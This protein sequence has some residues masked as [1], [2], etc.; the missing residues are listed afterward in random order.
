MEPIDK[1]GYKFLILKS[2]SYG[3]CYS[4]NWNLYSSKFLCES[5]CHP[6]SI[7][8]LEV[9][10]WHHTPSTTTTKEKSKIQTTRND[11]QWIKILVLWRSHMLVRDPD[12]DRGWPLIHTSTPRP[13]YWMFWVWGGGSHPCA[14]F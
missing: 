4:M 3:P 13:H 2:A 14:I 7:S 8:P 5:K 10:A 11:F 1:D 12:M 9:D 6:H